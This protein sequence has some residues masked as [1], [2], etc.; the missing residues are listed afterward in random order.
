MEAFGRTGAVGLALVLVTARVWSDPWN[1]LA[2]RLVKAQIDYTPSSP[3]AASWGATTSSVTIDVEYGAG[4]TAQGLLVYYGTRC[5]GAGKLAAAR[6]AGQYIV[7]VLSPRP[8]GMYSSDIYFLGVLYMIEW[9]PALKALWLNTL[10]CQ[11]DKYHAYPLPGAI[12]RYLANS[13]SPNLAAYDIAN[14]AVGANLGGHADAGAWRRGLIEAVN[15]LTATNES[16]TF[17]LACAVWGLASTGWMPAGTISAGYFTGVSYAALPAKLAA[18]QEWGGSDG[19]FPRFDKSG[20]PSTRDT[21]FAIPALSMVDPVWYAM[22]I[23]KAR[24]AIAEKILPNGDLDSSLDWTQGPMAYEPCVMG[25]ALA[26]MPV[27]CCC[28]LL[29]SFVRGDADNDRAID[30]GDATC[31]LDNLYNGAPTD[32][33]DAVDVNDDGHLDIADPVYIS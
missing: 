32:C 19:F 25:E 2:D 18:L 11:L 6:R 30:I 28:A 4:R 29:G 3:R 27:T 16:Q 8:E 13:T 20:R 22:P 7:Q 10:M 21:A 33:W 15:R 14:I 12:D 17:G 23:Q 1:R 31:A 9:D 26:A 5:G 24:E